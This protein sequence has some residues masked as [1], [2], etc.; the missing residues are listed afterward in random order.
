MVPHRR[1][2][3]RCVRR[4]RGLLDRVARCSK[5]TPSCAGG[6]AGRRSPTIA[7]SRPDQRA[8]LTDV[9]DARQLRFGDLV[10]SHFSRPRFGDFDERVAAAARGGHGRDRP[11]R[12]RVRA[13]APRRRA[14]SR[15]HPR[16]ARP[17]GCARV[18][19]AEVV[20]GW[21]ATAGE[22]RGAMS[23]H[24]GAG[25]RDGRRVRRAIPAGDRPV[26]VP[27]S[28][29]RRRRLRADCATGRRHTACWSASSGCR[30]PTSPP[31][32]TPRR[33]CVAAGGPMAATAPTS[34]ITCAAPTTCR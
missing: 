23:E 10:W 31:P 11:V 27:A 5:P 29:R 9:R 13:T 3:D 7:S 15:R 19:D 25:V 1:R 8:P 30:T 4:R 2:T 26:R 6:W 22:T 20:D 16:R 21:W 18:A 14:R 12:P 33:S 28:S 24:R 32:P 34:G 17:T